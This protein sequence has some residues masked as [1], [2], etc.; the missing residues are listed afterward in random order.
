MTTATNRPPFPA[1]VPNEENQPFWDALKRGELSLQACASCGAFQHPPRPMCS[2][3]G[4][5]ERTWKQVS[6]RGTVYSFVVTN[7][8]IHPA[9]EGFTPYATVLVELDE[10]PRMISN[11]TD[12]VIEDLAIG[13][14]VQVVFEPLSD[15][16]TLPLFRRA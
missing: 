16:I 15:E 12:V 8:A 14:P 2:D 11:L 4:S 6:G 1:P 5:M 10:G 9:Y 13:M 7:Q 3:C